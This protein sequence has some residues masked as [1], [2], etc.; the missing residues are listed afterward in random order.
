VIGPSAESIGGYEVSDTLSRLH[1]HSV[2]AHEKRASLV[3]D[4]APHA[5][6][7]DRMRHH[8]VVHKTI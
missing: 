7:M 4:L 5:M 3:Q 1:R 6:Q 8:G 2:L